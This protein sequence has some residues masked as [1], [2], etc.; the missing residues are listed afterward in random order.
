MGKDVINM[1]E[2]Y[3]FACPTKMEFGPGA[4]AKLPQVIEALHGSKVMLVTD[5]GV[6][7]AGLLDRVKAAIGTEYPYVVFDRV[8]SDPDTGII[9]EIHEQA[10][11]EQVDCMVAIGG[12]SPIDAA[13]GAACLMANP[14][15][16]RAYGGVDK[17]PQRGIPL[18]AIPTTAGTGSE[19]TIF[20]VLSDLEAEIKFTISSAL[21]APSVALCD[22]EMTLTL[23]PRV[24]AATGMDAMTHAVESYTS[25]IA[26]PVTDV[27]C[28]EAIRLLYR[29]LPVAVNNG[30]D[31]EARTHVL[32]AASLAGIVMND[33]YLGLSH[34][35][36]SPLGAHFHIPHGMANAVML[37]YVMEYN[38]MASPVK[39]AKIAEAMGLQTG[40]G[41]Y[42]DA[43]ATIAGI[44]KMAEL[45][46]TPRTLREVGAKEEVLK[47]VARDALLSIQLRFNCRSASE[48]QIYELVK[49]AY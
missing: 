29:Y 12:G 34:A 15:P 16:L 4:L 14:G 41:L 18:V 11:A 45:C 43:E 17:V 24:T 25:R 44:H 26:T 49:K 39:Y 10:Q 28:L 22:P 30:S 9:G 42:E 38:Y 8:R 5:P 27:L 33:A 48:E 21:I 32:L 36:A 1:L 47:D 20:A 7:Q 3:S 23:P 37:P 19:F 13:K 6:V 31:L 35:I 46:H 2:R 40:K